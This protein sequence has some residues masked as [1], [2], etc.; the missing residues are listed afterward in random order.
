MLAKTRVVFYVWSPDILYFSFYQ[1]RFSGIAYSIIS[2]KTLPYHT[3]R[4][5]EAHTG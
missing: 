2:N 4:Q 1:S 5:N 3:H